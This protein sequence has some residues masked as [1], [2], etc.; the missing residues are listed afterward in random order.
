[1]L[2]LLTYDGPNF[3]LRRQRYRGDGQWDY[4]KCDD[5]Y[6]A[7]RESTAQ[8]ISAAKIRQRRRARMAQILVSGPPQAV[9]RTPVSSC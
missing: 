1:M 5:F 4:G 7:E 8:A 6:P 9:F 3:D 2:A